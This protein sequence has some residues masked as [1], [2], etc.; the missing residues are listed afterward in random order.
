MLEEFNFS[1]SLSACVHTHSFK[2]IL[3]L[4][5]CGER[6]LKLKLQ[7]EKGTM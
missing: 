4:G 5:F 2:N 7:G 6:K 3:T 1:I